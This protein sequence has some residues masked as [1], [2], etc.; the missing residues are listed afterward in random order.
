VVS[1]Y[2]NPGT[3]KSRLVGEFKSTLDLNR[4]TWLEGH[5]YPYSQSI[6]YSPVIDLMNRAWRIEEGDPPEKIREKVES[7]LGPLL[8]GREDLLPYIGNLYA[9]KYPEIEGISPE[10]WRAHFFEALKTLVVALAQRGPTVFYFEDIHWADRSTLDLLRF[11][12]SET[13]SPILFLNVYRLPFS[14]FA[15]CHGDPGGRSNEEIHLQDFSLADS[16]DMLR[17]MLKMEVIPD[18]LNR[19]VLEKD[20]GNPFF[21][22][23]MVNSMIESGAFVRENGDWILTRTITEYDTPSTVQGVIS[24][25]LDLLKYE[26]KRVLQE[27]AVIGRAFYVDILRRVSEI[28][29]NLDPYLQGLEG[30][31]IVRVR[32]V[33]PDLEYIFK[34]VLT[35]EVVYNGLLK[36]ERQ[37]IH[38]RIGLVMEQV[39]QVRLSEFYETLAFHFKQGRS[40]MKAVHYLMKS[41][42]KSLNRYAVDQSHQYYTEAFELLS[43]KPDRTASDD[44]LLIQLLLDWGFVFYYRSDW[45]GFEA[46]LEENETL[47]QSQD[48]K[49]LLGMFYAWFGFSDICRDKYQTAYQ[50]LQIALGIGEEIEDPRVIG[51]ACTWL[52][53]SCAE[54]GL[55]DEGIAYG[56]RAMEISGIIPSDQY[57][58][59]KSVA[60]TT[61]C[62]SYQGESKK[63][64]ELGQVCVEYGLQHGNVRCLSMGHMMTA[65]AHLNRGDLEIAIKSCREAVAA[66]ADPFY[67]ISSRSGLSI[68]YVMKGDFSSADHA[69][70]GILEQCEVLGYNY[71]STMAQLALGLVLMAKGQMSEG[72]NL[73]EELLQHTFTCGRRW[74]YIFSECCLGNVYLQMVK[75]EGDLHLSAIL[76]NVGFLIKNVPVASRKAAAHFNK[77]IQAAEEI[78]ANGLLGQAYLGLGRLHQA[79]KRKTKA[80]ECL[81]KAIDCFDRCQAETI[82]KQTREELGSLA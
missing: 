58:F 73:I 1:I 21:M 61:L 7:N 60:G 23:E 56:E 12:L 41:G 69:L 57:L 40:V 71:G 38:E 30:L 67:D 8:E 47:V 53:W 27:A 17:S 35:Q 10:Y 15:G 37:E 62:H 46:L 52:A 81:L 44:R 14:L 29:D 28:Q 26:M 59:Y 74:T 79:K 18:E 80:R 32:S 34:H 6:P 72:L 9:L 2:G 13:K 77:A 54:M 25:R 63:G 3:G 33:H 48:D 5:A 75:G 22:E 78:G 50:R 19:I 82:L 36:K 4:I 24:A 65:T 55:F 49:A 76:K 68:A 64:I 31:D 70:Q 66:A 43:A 11:L 16:V 42:A 20:E 51:Y 45:R 39:F